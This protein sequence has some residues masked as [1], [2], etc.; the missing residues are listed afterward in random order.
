M[1][2]TDKSG[3]CDLWKAGVIDAGKDGRG[4]EELAIAASFLRLVLDAANNYYRS[5]LK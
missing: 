1:T 5:P 3:P 4:T 2:L